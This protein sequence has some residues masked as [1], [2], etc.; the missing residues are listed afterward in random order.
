MAGVLPSSACRRGGSTRLMCVAVATDWRLWSRQVLP[1]FAFCGTMSGSSRDIEVLSLTSKDFQGIDPCGIQD[2]TYTESYIS[3]IGV[4]FVSCP[5]PASCSCCL[6]RACN[7]TLLCFSTENQNGGARRQGHQAADCKSQAKLERS[8]M[9]TF[10]QTRSGGA[11]SCYA[12]V[13]HSWTRKVPNNHQQLLQ[14]RSWHYRKLLND[15]PSPFSWGLA[16]QPSWCL[17]ITS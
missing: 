14:G 15:Q 5:A 13:G 12:A 8:C 1:S 4:D 3:T 16:A 11:N 7:S 2:D 9:P 10:G 6:G 17:A